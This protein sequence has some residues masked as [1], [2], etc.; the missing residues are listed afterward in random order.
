V[1]AMDVPVVSAPVAGRMRASL[2][3]E[4]CRAGP[5]QRLAY[6]AS[7]ALI[8]VGVAYWVAWL[9]VGGAWQ[10][11][12]SF[13]KPATFW[14]S[15]GLTTITLAW[16]AGWLRVCG[17]TRWLLL[18]PLAVADATEVAWV[19]VQRWR[20]VA[21]HSN[22]A[23]RLDTALFVVGGA[24]IAVAMHAIQVLPVLAWL[25]SFAAL[26][27]LRRVGLVWAATAPVRGPGGGQRGPDRRRAG[28]LRPRRGRR[29]PDPGRGGPAG[30]RLRRRAA[31]PAPPGGCAH[32][33]GQGPPRAG[34]AKQGGA[35]ASPRQEDRLNAPAGRL[36]EPD[37]TRKTREREQGGRH[38]ARPARASNA[39]AAA[40]SRA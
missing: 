39:T 15:F 4:W 26:A 25:L 37:V 5:A 7:G 34:Q 6:L 30:R 10:G 8:V 2:A 1:R 27:E 28:A 40:R 17:R 12:V 16:V 33:N 32:L 21:S 20:G 18:G 14:V 9:V 22:F 38:G 29:R 24:A 23:T 11:P 13:R 3:G 19:A 35:S 31:R 36:G